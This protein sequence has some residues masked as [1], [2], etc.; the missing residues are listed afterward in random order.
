MGIES[1]SGTG[2]ISIP[3]PAAKGSN[4]RDSQGK[5]IMVDDVAALS[6]GVSLPRPS[7]RPTPSFRDVSGDAIHT[8]FFPFSIGPYYATYPEDG[9]AG[10]FK[11]TREEW[12]APY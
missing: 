7:F 8:D 5:G 11:L 12:D 1:P 10:N 6:A 3:T 4:T 9:V 2:F